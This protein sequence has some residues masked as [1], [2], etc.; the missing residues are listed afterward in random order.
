MKNLCNE[1]T[2][3]EETMRIEGSGRFTPKPYPDEYES[4]QEFRE[5]IRKVSEQAKQ[6]AK[7][8][9]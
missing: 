3:S 7:N 1:L 2:H 5:A 6:E 9:P 4:E 8:E